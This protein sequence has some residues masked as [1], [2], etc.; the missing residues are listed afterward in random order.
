MT[1]QI[2]FRQFSD[3]S[4]NRSVCKARKRAIF[5]VEYLGDVLMKSCKTL[6]YDYFDYNLSFWVK[7]K[8]G[9]ISLHLTFELAIKVAQKVSS[10]LILMGRYN[11]S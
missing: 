1:S 6:D 7:I 2:Q 3:V 5:N 9:P 4:P 10:T 11:Q 8:P